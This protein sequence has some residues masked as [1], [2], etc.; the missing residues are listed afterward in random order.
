[1]AHKVSHKNIA[2]LAALFLASQLYF[3]ISSA[4]LVI[5]IPFGGIFG[6][7][8]AIFV[9]AVLSTITEAIK[10]LKD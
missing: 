3:I 10:S 7:V 1:M 9:G 5:E 4:P 2:Q 8:A 6:I